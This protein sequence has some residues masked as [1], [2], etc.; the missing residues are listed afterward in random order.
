MKVL[1]TGASGFIGGHLVRKLVDRGLDVRILIRKT[2]NI[3]HIGDLELEKAYGDIT[4]YDSV[5]KAMDGVDQV[6]H[7]AALYKAWQPDS[8]TFYRINVEGTVNVMN[9]A[10]EKNIERI[11]YTSTV[12]AVGI[13]EK[14]GELC[15]ENCL[16]NLGFSEDHYII[17]KFQAEMEVMKMICKR[18]LPAVIVNPSA[19]VG[20]ADWKPTP[21][22]Q[23]I[24]Q[25]LKKRIPAYVDTSISFV[26]VRDVAEG[27]ILAMEKGKIG[28]RYILTDENLTMKEL[29]EKLYKITGIKP[30]KIKTPYGVN[31]AFA[32]F[33]EFVASI[34]GI[35]PPL[36]RS[37]VR[38]TK[39]RL[40]YDNRKSREELGLQY[41]GVEKALED[42]VKWYRENG[43]V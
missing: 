18:G 2:S 33:L 42:A 30:P 41:G 31:Y 19:P 16:W 20:P 26:D 3:S 36:A 35:E 37:Y 7:V 38:V 43:Y 6:Y 11:V 28:E 21:T 39:G 25:Y 29:F 9:A 15:D 13:V 8:R 34:T 5:L 23:L 12:G 17:S 10:L 14:E 4:D 1:V 40:A 32:S 22:G 27:H 24:V